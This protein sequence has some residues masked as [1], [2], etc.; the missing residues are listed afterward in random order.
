MQNVPFAF[1]MTDPNL[2]TSPLSDFRQQ[3]PAL[4]QGR[5]YFNYGGQGPLPDSAIY[6]IH[7]GI[8]QF[9]QLGPFSGKANQWVFEETEKTRTAIARE[10]GAT[11]DTVSL[12][13]DVSVG[14]NIALWGIDWRFGDHLLMSDCEHPGIVAAIRELQRRF[15]IEVSVFPLQATLNGGDPLAVIV[16]HLRPDT[17]LVVIG[18]VLWNTGQILP[19]REIVAA[20]HGYRRDRPPL[21]MVDAAQSVGMLPLNL[22]ETGVDFYAFTGHKWLC[23]P[24]GL[25]GL[26]VSPTAR[27]NLH[28]TFIGWRSIAMDS[29]GNPTGFKPDGRRYEVATSAYPLWAGLRASISI[30]Q[31]FGSAEERFQRI[32]TMSKR[33]WQELT[34]LGSVSCLRSHPPTSGLVSFRLVNQAHANLVKFLE[35]RD[36]FVRTILNP[37]CV[38]ACVHYF[39]DET[40]IERLV[41]AIAEFTA[42]L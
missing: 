37:D 32:Q 23:G 2:E 17:R 1:T 16:D 30:H 3:F 41:S 14:C 10:L 38:R 28:P 6:A 22:P 39:T 4:R 20:C 34:E 8:N 36:I 7:Q 18:H 40:E 13:E 27:E 19:L 26:Y 29:Q 5:C 42:R 31:Q 9:Q 11:P 25:G 15:G 24:E 33:L 21:V 12:T 35:E